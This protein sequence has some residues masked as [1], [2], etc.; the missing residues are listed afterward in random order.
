MQDPLTDLKPTP[1]N[2]SKY[3]YPV[4]SDMFSTSMP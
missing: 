1:T 2:E 4:H 3:A